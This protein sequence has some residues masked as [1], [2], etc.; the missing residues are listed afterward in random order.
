MGP[1][2]S[3]DSQQLLS[4]KFDL[5][6]NQLHKHIFMSTYYQQK[7]TGLHKYDMPTVSHLESS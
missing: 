5:K 4:M 3:F 7:N 1:Q 2:S 6:F